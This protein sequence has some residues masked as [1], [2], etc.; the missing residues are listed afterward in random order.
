MV[1]DYAKLQAQ[2]R[3][4]VEQKERITIELTEEKR[5][6]VASFQARIEQLEQLLEAMRFTDRE[7]LVDTIDVWKRA[8][9]RVCIARDEMEEEYQGQ[10]VTKDKQLRKMALDN[11]EERVASHFK[12]LNI[13]RLWSRRPDCKERENVQREMDKEGW[14]EA[15]ISVCRVVTRPSS[16]RSWNR[17]HG[18]SGRRIPR[19]RSSGRFGDPDGNVIPS[20]KL[21]ALCQVHL[22]DLALQLEGGRNRKGLSP[23]QRQHVLEA[24]G[25]MQRMN[26][27]KE[28]LS[29]P[30]E[31]IS[32][33][34]SAMDL[35]PLLGHSSVEGLPLGICVSSPSM[36][37]TTVTIEVDQPGDFLL[38]I[39]SSYAHR[40]WVEFGVILSQ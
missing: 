25:L 7:E 40:P 24:A 27:D 31:A 38:D 8:Y 21:I 33:A 18:P 34:L 15:Y 4:E 3:N 9:E 1:G 32:E 36:R 10:L 13:Q 22:A 14:D 16:I 39:D 2:F 6:I 29:E 30:A 20:G 37:H 35:V 11:A 26:L 5:A 28:P 23:A 19:I 12:D 17:L